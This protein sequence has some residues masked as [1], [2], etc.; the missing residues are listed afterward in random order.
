MDN[1]DAGCNEQAASRILQ[2]EHGSLSTISEATGGRA[3]L[4][5]NDFAGAMAEAIDEGS[6]YYTL[7]FAPTNAAHNGEFHKIKVQLDRRDLTLAYRPGYT[8]DPP[9]KKTRDTA[10]TSIASSTENLMKTMTLG[11]PTPT[12]MLL[13]IG[14]MPIT[15]AGESEDKPA[16]GNLTKGDMHGPYRRYNVNYYIGR[17]EI[18]FL[19]D[20]TGKMRADL[21]FV[22]FVFEPD[23]TLV[24][25]TSNTMHLNGTREEIKLAVARGLF[26]HQEVIVPA[27]GDVLPADSPYMT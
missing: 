17:S 12:E 24:N 21:E 2:G 27:K 11:T 7:T 23:G 8:A 19:P 26:Y 25:A 18:G 20:E 1:N 16:P 5:T 3:F 9:E 6:S 13:H 10:P 15:P 4:E 14:V 22:I